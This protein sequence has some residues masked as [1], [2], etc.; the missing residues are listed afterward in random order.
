VAQLIIALVVVQPDSPGG[1]AY[2]EPAM[3]L[4]EG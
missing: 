2:E 1:R 3:A 4:H